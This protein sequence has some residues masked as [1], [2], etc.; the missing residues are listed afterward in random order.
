MIKLPPIVMSEPPV[1]PDHTLRRPIGRG[2]YGEVWLARNVMGAP[3]A[4]KIV[5][6]RQFESDR[7]YEREFAGIQRYEPVSRSA[8]GLVHVLHVGRNDAA[9]YFY[10]VM[11]LADSTVPMAEPFAETGSGESAHVPELTPLVAY[12]PRT[13]RSDLK[14]LGQLPFHDCVRVALDVVG[15]LAR[16]HERGLIHRDVKPG[17]II[18]VEG[19][20]KLADIGL[21]SRESEGRTFVG[22][23]GYI[24]PEGPGSPG[25]DLYALG[26]VLYE[27][28]TG[29]PPDLFPKVPS[30][31]FAADADTAALEFHA[32]VLRACEGDKA[33]RYQS[34]EEMQ[35]DLALLQS[36][37]SVRHVRA[38][39]ERV[40]R[41][42][43][44]GWMAAACVTAAVAT[45]LTANWK[46]S[47]AAE[48]RANEARLR[49]QAQRS[50]TRAET[51]ER[52]SQR[53]LYTALLEQ[54]R[55]TVR[56]G[57][58]GQRVR[59]LDA[60]RRAAAISNSVDLR[61]EGMAALALPDLEKERELAF[62]RD[63]TLVQPDPMFTRIAMA[64]SRGPVEI[65]SLTNDQLLATLP[66]STNL[67][68]YSALWSGD[69]RFLAVNR[70][71]TS[72]GDR[73]DLEVWDLEATPRQ[74]VVVRDARYKARAFH[75]G[76]RE[77]LVGGANGLIT[78]WDLQTGRELG[79]ATFEVS[80]REL[81]Y[82][83]DGRFT[84]AVYP[85]EEGWGASVH[86]VAD[87]SFVCSNVFPD[88]VVSVSWDPR[89]RNIALSDFGG[90]IHLMDARTG[91]RVALGRHHA[92][93]VSTTFNTDGRYLITGAWGRELLCWDVLRQERALTLGVESYVAQFRADGL[94]CA[95]WTSS[96]V[97]FH[98]FQRPALHVELG[99]ELFP[100][101]RHVALSPDGHWLAASSDQQ[102]AVWHLAKPGPA[103][104]V[105]EAADAR[106]YWSLEGE[107]Y[108]GQSRRAVAM[109]WRVS[110]ATN[111]WSP[112]ILER[113][114]L[115]VPTRFHSLSVT[116]NRV[117]WTSAAGSLVRDVSE[118]TARE[119]NWVPTLRGINTLSPDGRWLAIYTPYTPNVAVYRLPGLIEVARLTSKSRVSGF[120]FTPRSDEL[121]VSSNGQTEFWSTADW[122]PTR[123]KTNSIGL[124]GFGVIFAPD[125]RTV[126]LAQSLRWAGLYDLR[127]FELQLPL[128]TG[129]LP[130]A[131]SADGSQLVV[132]VDGRRLQVW[133]LPALREELGKLGLGW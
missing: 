91:Q 25:A 27:A 39:E 33:R 44:I 132:S 127:T 54:A 6:R 10:Y 130:L 3:R 105:K 18:Y 45:A 75:P 4:V 56:S 119:T 98:S 85:R 124:P 23:E 24:P 16:L 20:A 70:D 126:W 50:L 83:P 17:N 15:G 74:V 104:L 59:A 61:R 97:Q 55:A 87:G 14:Q 114:D 131:L 103:A 117:A 29:Y 108:G 66:A 43:R 113:R 37:Q 118:V 116:S 81:A 11:E 21:V 48:S 42:R 35:A 46:A 28:V 89:G 22:T 7:P 121:A 26:M 64:R 80:P 9:G 128:P 125:G 62:G 67:I 86:H 120:A 107:L 102:F 88:R 51:A 95:I 79:R 38:L 71:Y 63:H 57:E 84:A 5:W 65:R 53:Q 110:P 100:R 52:E 78:L 19:R 73:S 133:N 49:E 77:L 12:V 94:A 72:D 34:A 60:I 76:R 93:A 68:C 101:V 41:W 90:N 30:A 99:E 69:G 58:M 115:F 13:L 122:G 31:W 82:S 36:G 112:P 2:A 47:V 96:G 123:T 40:R 111:A 92:E 109:R 129:M 8:D 1:I 106:P 32:V